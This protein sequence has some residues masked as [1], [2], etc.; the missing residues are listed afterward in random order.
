MV[1]DFFVNDEHTKPWFVN[2]NPPP[3]ACVYDADC[4]DGDSST[5]DTCTPVGICF[6]SDLGEQC[7]K[8][9]DCTC[10]VCY[11][12]LC[13][14]EVACDGGGPPPPPPPPGGGRLTASW[15]DLDG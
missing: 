2:E 8:D 1:L 6:N 12:G 3:P 7:F 11:G 10:G 13:T 9:I 5:I 15:L 4:N 14:S